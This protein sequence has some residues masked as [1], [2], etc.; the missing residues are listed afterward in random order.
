MGQAAARPEETLWEGVDD[1]GRSVPVRDLHL[2]LLV[3][4]WL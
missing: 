3:S 2:S 4:L 1:G